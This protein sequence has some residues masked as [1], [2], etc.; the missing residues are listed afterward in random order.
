MMASGGVTVPI[1]IPDD[2]DIPYL[3]NTSNYF[4]SNETPTPAYEHLHMPVILQYKSDKTL[5]YKNILCH[6]FKC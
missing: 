2:T 6:L 3:T 1:H 5:S 4:K